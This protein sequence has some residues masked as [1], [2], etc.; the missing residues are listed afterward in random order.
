MNYSSVVG[1]DSSFYYWLKL[2]QRCANII[3]EYTGINSDENEV[4][5]LWHT[6]ETGNITRER[7][8]EQWYLSII[9]YAK[10]LVLKVIT[11]YYQKIEL[12]NKHKFKWYTIPSLNGKKQLDW[13]IIMWQN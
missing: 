8:G 7:C 10:Q 13:V 5:I 12:N 2:C 3:P 1:R 6:N 9:D 11:E 4:L